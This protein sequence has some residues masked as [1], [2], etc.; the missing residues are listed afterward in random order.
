MLGSIGESWMEVCVGEKLVFEWPTSL[1]MFYF[2]PYF[3]VFLGDA[4]I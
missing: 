4:L 1:I 2:T 3:M